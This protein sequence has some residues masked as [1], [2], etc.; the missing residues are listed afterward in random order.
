MEMKQVQAEWGQAIAAVK[1]AQIRQIPVVAGDPAIAPLSSVLALLAVLSHRVEHQMMERR[2]LNKEYLQ[3]KQ[4]IA[5]MPLDSPV[6]VPVMAEYWAALVMTEYWAVP[7]MAEYWAA[8]E[9]CRLADRD[10]VGIEM[11]WVQAD[12][13]QA[14]AAVKTVQMSHLSVVAE[15]SAIASL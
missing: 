2:H 6:S 11:K 3:E 9:A 15:N 8:L 5:L 12:W 1:K 7:V 14:I 13:V 10:R 4:K